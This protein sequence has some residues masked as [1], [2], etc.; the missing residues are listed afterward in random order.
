MRGL[1]LIP[2]LVGGLAC[3]DEQCTERAAC[4]GE[5]M[6]VAL[7][8]DDGEVVAAEGEYRAGSARTDSLVVS[9]D[10]DR[11]E[12]SDTYACVDGEL[13]VGP[14]W[15]DD[16]FLDLRFELPDGTFTE[17]LP[18]PLE[19]TSETDPDFN[20]EGC[21]CTTYSGSAEPFVVPAEARP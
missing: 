14:P 20:G 15:A 1:W 13:S 7:V 17:W 12:E 3:E 9:F 10:C 4:V 5:I 16:F 18:V 11:D 6:Q 8:D 21:P 2:M 19:V